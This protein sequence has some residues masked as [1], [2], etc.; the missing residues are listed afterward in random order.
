[1]LHLSYIPS[2]TIMMA[3]LH[4]SHNPLGGGICGS[5]VPF[6]IMALCLS[7]SVERHL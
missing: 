2:G 3:K 4:L 6:V 7:Q 5:N 1:M